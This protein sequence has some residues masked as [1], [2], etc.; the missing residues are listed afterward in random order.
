MFYIDIVETESVEINTETG[1]IRDPEEQNNQDVSG[2]ND[3]KKYPI[4]YI[5]FQILKKFFI[6]VW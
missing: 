1:S 2:W 5:H 3:S 6:N 4:I